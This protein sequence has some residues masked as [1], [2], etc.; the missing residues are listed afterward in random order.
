MVRRTVPS[1]PPPG[2]VEIPIIRTIDN[3]LYKSVARHKCLRARVVGE[4]QDKEADSEKK[5]PHLS[6]Y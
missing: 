3:I 2:A 6:L 5:P 4:N 1:V